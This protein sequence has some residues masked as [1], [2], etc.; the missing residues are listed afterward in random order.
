MLT[1]ILQWGYLLCISYC[2]GFLFSLFCEKVLG[3][4]FERIEAYLLTGIIILTVYAQF[5][6]LFYK[7]GITANVILLVITALIVLWKRK[8]LASR[9]SVAW[10]GSSVLCKVVVLVLFVMW[11]FFTSRGYM[12]YD[13]DLYHAQSIQ[14]I[15]EYGIVKGLGNLHNRFAYNSSVFSLHALLSM[16]YLT[17]GISL[18]TANGFIAFLLSIATVKIGQAWKR[19]KLRLSDYARIGAIYYLTTI[20][21]EVLAPSSDYSVMCMVFL[22]IITWLDLL[23]QKEEKEQ[24]IVP[25]CLLCVVGV[26]TL[27]LK[28]TAGLILLLLLKPAVYLLKNKRWKE[29]G[30]YL[31]MGLLVAAPWMIRTVVISGW[32]IYPFPALD[33]FHPDWKMPALYASVDAMEIQVWGR[34]LYNVEAIGL[35]ITEWFGNWFLSTLQATEKLLIL[36]DIASLVIV[37]IAL[38]VILVKRRWEHLELLLVLVTIACSYAYWQTSAPLTRYGYAYIL[39][40]AV[41][42]IG[43][44]VSL[45]GFQWLDRAARLAVLML[46]VYKLVWIVQYTVDYLPLPYY[47]LPQDY[48]TFELEENYVDGHLI[49]TPKSGDRTGYYSFPAVPSVDRVTLRG[50]SFED[51]FRSTYQE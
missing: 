8:A 21:D 2:L 35:P 39:L 47:V 31:L 1:V 40:L 46:A 18:H 43:W 3:Y 38:V 29:I 34:A 51:G 16:K 4:R 44:L 49:Y 12:M 6:S 45:T 42:T 9:V 15:E 28:L 14:W 22:I 20:C 48:T 30:I 27:T 33:L 41:L 13:T 23:E 5:F 32:L 25:Y 50:D 10:Q 26:Y 17:G 24:S 37:V 7:V 36:A 19:K 11:A